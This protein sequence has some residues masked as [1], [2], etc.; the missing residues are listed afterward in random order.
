MAKIAI[1]YHSGFGHTAVVALEVAA[2]VGQAGGEPVLI[3]LE[4]AGQDFTAALEAASEADAII[5]GAPTYIGDVSAVLKAFFEASSKV[6]M[7]GGWRDKL[8]G[9]FTN[10]LSFAGDKHHALASISPWRCSRAW[11]GLAPG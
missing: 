5:F 9:G 3:R 7:Q 4:S 8:A 10:S 1:V 6:W 2:G 11:F